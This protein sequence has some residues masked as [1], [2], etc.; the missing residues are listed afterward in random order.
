MRRAFV[1]NEDCV[2]RSA[3]VADDYPAALRVGDRVTLSKPID[4]G[5]QAKL[6]EGESGFVDYID[7]ST[8]CVE[9]K[10][11]TFHPGLSEWS[12]HMWLEPFGTEDILDSVVCICR[13]IPLTRVA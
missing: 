6:A 5:Y 7:A 8:G 12:N 9:I 1:M 10:L 11:D 4:L 3:L 13:V 2:L